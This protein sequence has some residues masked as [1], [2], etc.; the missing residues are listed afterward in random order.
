MSYIEVHQQLHAGVVVL[1]PS[2]ATAPTPPPAPPSTPSPAAPFEW[3]PPSAPTRRRLG[4]LVDGTL[5]PLKPL[6]PFVRES[7][8]AGSAA[9]DATDAANATSPLSMSTGS[10]P[11]STASTPAEAATPW[12]NNSINATMFASEVDA[13]T[14]FIGDTSIAN[15]IVKLSSSASFSGPLLRFVRR[16]KLGAALG[17][18]RWLVARVVE[19][20]TSH[21]MSSMVSVHVPAVVDDP[22]VNLDL[23]F[24]DKQKQS[25][26]ALY[27]IV[28]TK[29]YTDQP[30][31]S[32]GTP[33]RSKRKRK[34]SLL[35]QSIATVVASAPTSVVKGALVL[36]DLPKT[37]QTK[38]ETHDAATL[39]GCIL[40]F[41]SA[42]IGSSATPWRS[43]WT[44]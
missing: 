2:D 11:P 5:K 30:G 33:S 23:E 26:P 9:T 39:R 43:C 22:A 25:L 37:C 41:T 8:A 21:L 14:L 29:C 4:L 12:L 18:L 6:K 19:L 7:P 44:S 17:S 3:E 15:T 36:R 42:R 35:L 24:L 27:H 34:L 1:P 32:A 28:L 31:A 13:T 16:Q 10:T 40:N 20:A 38:L